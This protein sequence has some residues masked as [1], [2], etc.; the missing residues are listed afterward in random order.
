MGAVGKTE[1]Q[2][3][4]GNCGSLTNIVLA[5]HVQSLGPGSFWVCTSLTN[6]TLG[7]SLTTIGE[8]AFALCTA[9]T[10]VTIPASVSTIGSEA[11]YYAFNLSAL[12]FRGGAPYLPNGAIFSDGNGLVYYLPG[13]IGW[14]PTCGGRSTKLWLPEPLT[15]DSS[16]GV[17]TN[18]FGFT[19]AWARGR[20][21]VV[22][23]SAT[24]AP[25]VW[26][27][28]ATNTLTSD[29]LPFL[30]PDWRLYP[31]RFYCLRFRGWTGAGRP[32]DGLWTGGIS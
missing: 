25:S 16:F 12:R 26:S 31:A 7:N 22:E 17:Q 28:I 29:T 27:P 10:E 21:V 5:N 18:G 20:T 24:L 30:D 14:Q 3:S 32:V 13:T 2:S 19:I 8:N 6:I 23:T 9:L 1:G 4:F 11:F 15:S